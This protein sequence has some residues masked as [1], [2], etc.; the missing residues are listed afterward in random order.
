MRHR[1]ARAWL[2]LLTAALLAGS[3]AGRPEERAP[4]EATPEDA[5]SVK[6]SHWRDAFAATEVIQRVRPTERFGY[7]P[8]P[9][10]GTTT[11]QR[12]NG[13]ALYPDIWWNDGVAPVEFKP[14]D[15]NVKNENYPDTTIAYCRWVWRAIEPKKGKYRWDIIDGALKAAR[16]RGQTL[17]VRPQR[18]P[19]LVHGNIRRLQQPHLN[20]GLLHAAHQ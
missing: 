7:I 15:G 6:T 12:F 20:G 16:E 3:C 2:L 19:P 11:F 8:N 17:Q 18:G 5:A 4:S 1:L 14:F 9:H 10:R 13:D